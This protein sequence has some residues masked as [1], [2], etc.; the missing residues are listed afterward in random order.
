MP[1]LACELGGGLYVVRLGGDFFGWQLVLYGGFFSAVGALLFSGAFYWLYAGVI[2]E[3]AAR[4]RT[5]GGAFD[6]VKAAL[7]KRYKYFFIFYYYYYYYY[8]YIGKQ[9]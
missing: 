5:S 3:L 1:S 9:H 8:I 6:F 2:T 4:Y 7:G